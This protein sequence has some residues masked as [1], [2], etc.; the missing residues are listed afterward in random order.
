M[1]D[2]AWM[3]V[4]VPKLVAVHEKIKRFSMARYS[5]IKDCYLI[6]LCSGCL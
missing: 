2:V 4:Y 6:P 3:E 1:E 5:K